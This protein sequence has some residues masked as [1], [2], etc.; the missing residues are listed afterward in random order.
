MAAR[1]YDAAAGETP[2]RELLVLGVDHHGAGEPFALSTLPWRTPLGVVP[3]AEE[4]LERL[5]LDPIC[6]DD[7]AHTQEHSIEVQLPFLQVVL[8]G[9]PM[10]ALSIRF[11][12]FS[13]LRETAR[14]IAAAVEGR[15]VLLIAST[16]FSH[17]VAPG[18]ARRLDSLAIAQIVAREAEGLYRTVLQHEISMCGVAPTTVLL[19][20][21]REEPLT[22]RSLGWS[23]SGEVEPMAQVVGYSSA[24]L[25][26]A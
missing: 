16:D 4:L 24:V 21:L 1:A 19:E 17:Y 12:P 14:R 2:P 25:E 5:D 20:A 8:P 9:V 3:V 23:H 26:A 7:S 22:V 13:R 10:A 11:G 6:R 18:T 15:D